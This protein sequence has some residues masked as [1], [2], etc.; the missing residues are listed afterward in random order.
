MQPLLQALGLLCSV[1]EYDVARAQARSALGYCQWT[2]LK[3]QPLLQVLG[4]LCSVAEYP[5]LRV[6]GFGFMV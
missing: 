2:R 5:K 4:L 6:W 1:A 3:G